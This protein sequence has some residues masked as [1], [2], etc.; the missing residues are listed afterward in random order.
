MFRTL[1]TMGL[2]ATLSAGFVLGAASTDTLDHVQAEV[3]GQAQR[4]PVPSG[5]QQSVV[6]L[7]KMAATLDSIDA[8]LARIEAAV[9]EISNDE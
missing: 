4:K 5:A 2:L 9:T 7:R 1:K 6:V 8:R 3:R